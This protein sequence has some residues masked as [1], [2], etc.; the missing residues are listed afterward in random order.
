MHYLIMYVLRT[1]FKYSTV[2]SY[3]VFS[4]FFGPLGPIWTSA[5]SL[6]MHLRCMPADGIY[7]IAST[8][9]LLPMA[10][11]TSATATTNPY[12]PQT[13]TQG[14]VIEKHVE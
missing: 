10:L 4:P 7:Q 5:L 1:H 13:V 12:K 3:N 2:F 6:S 14:K 8:N 9:L 11:P